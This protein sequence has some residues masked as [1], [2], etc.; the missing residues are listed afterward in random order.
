MISLTLA[1][2]LV[3]CVT[4]LP[5]SADTQEST[6][7]YS[8]TEITDV[9]TLMQRAL[10]GIDELKDNTD[11]GISVTTAQTRSFSSETVSAPYITSQLLHSEIVDGNQI[12]L[13]VGTVLRTIYSDSQSRTSG[14]LVS[15]L[16]FNYDNSSN[17]VQM[18]NTRATITT[19]GA[20]RLVMTNGLRQ[21]ALHNLI[22]TS[23]QY[24][25]PSGTYYLNRCS[26]TWISDG[27]GLLYLNNVLYFDSGSSYKT[28]FSINRYG[29]FWN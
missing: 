13:Y 6:V 11:Y 3:F 2:A 8:A 14:S 28:E 17:R 24:S 7:L 12:D 26:S 20:S 18:V 5:V 16:Y 25:N 23:A 21:S 29:N 19:S 10:A 1:F 22:T 27:T 15:T 9:D 4:I